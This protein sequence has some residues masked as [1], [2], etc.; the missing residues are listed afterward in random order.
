MLEGREIIEERKK[1]R[2]LEEGKRRRQDGRVKGMKRGGRMS[3]G[4][5]L[6]AVLNN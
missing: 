5:S 6:R 2:R 4:W 1:H 3:V